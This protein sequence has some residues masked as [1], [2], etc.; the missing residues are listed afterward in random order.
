MLAA[1][2]GFTGRSR[3]MYCLIVVLLV[4]QHCAMLGS[5]SC[6]AGIQPVC[7]ELHMIRSPVQAKVISHPEL[8]CEC[9][10]DILQ[11]PC[12]AGGHVVSA[13]VGCAFR[14]ALRNAQWVG[15]PLSMA[16]SLLAMQ[17]TR[18]VHPPGHLFLQTISMQCDLFSCTCLRLH[19]SQHQQELYSSIPA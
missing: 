19:D 17:L 15:A 13:A 8:R 16:T 1:L 2:D 3:S 5:R 10:L 18:T 7:Q 9:S 14:L 6:S 4:W 12:T 11:S